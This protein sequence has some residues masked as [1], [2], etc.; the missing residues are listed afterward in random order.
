LLG[1]RGLDTTGDYLTTPMP[2]VGELVGGELAWR[3]HEGGHTVGPNWP[4]FFEWVGRYIQAPAL[5]T[6]SARSRRP[7]AD[8]PTPR[9]DENS[10]IAHEELINKAKFGATQGRIDVYFVGDSITRRWGCTDPQYQDLL[11]SWTKNFHGWN[12]ANLAG[13]ATRRATFC[14]V[15]KTESWAD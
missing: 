1:A 4:S 12:A 14:G 6:A 10:R 7:A 3:Q 2:P 15:S 9:Q 5:P 8:E 13:E 11:D